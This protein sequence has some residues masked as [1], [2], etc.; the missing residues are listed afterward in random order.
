M[1]TDQADAHFAA[2]MRDNLDLA[3]RH[4][5]LD[6]TGEPI[7]G[8]RLRSI[9]AQAEDAQ[10]P[11]W[12][13]VV[14]Q[15]PE[16]AQGNPWT[17]TLAANE[18]TGVPKPYVLDIF[19]WTDGRRQRAEVM[20]LVKGQ[21]CSPTDAL[22]S[23]MSLSDRWWADLARS[24]GLLADTRTDRINS[25]QNKVTQR[26]RER[27]GSPVATTVDQWETVHGDLHWSNL[28]RPT[29][30][31]L[32]WELWG[33]GPAGTDAATLLCY[34][35]LVPEIATTVRGLFGDVLDSP[36]GQVAQLYVV[37][38]LLRRIDGGDHP[39]LAEPLA[40]HANSLLST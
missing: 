12:L 3:A 38:R 20:T 21:R 40:R 37:A 30:G 32:D 17:G 25:D 5:D 23:T 24:L 7:F 4:F 22:R 13:R 16:W 14:S 34:S 2:W 19:E 15:E 8:W 9:G 33:R 39:E 18:I 29:L 27:F 11:R 1:N 31:L 10:G 35:L 36:T 6:I 28:M 26:I